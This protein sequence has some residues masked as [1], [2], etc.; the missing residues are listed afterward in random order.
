M[1][2]RTRRPSRRSRRPNQRRSNIVRTVSRLRGNKPFVTRRIASDPPFRNLNFQRTFTHRI[3]C[4]NMPGSTSGFILPV[5]SWDSVVFNVGSTDPTKANSNM[6]ITPLVIHSI[7]T[8]YYAKSHIDFAVN[9]VK[10]W[11][12][13]REDIPIRLEFAPDETDRQSTVMA[14]DVGTATRRARIGFATPQL[15]WLTL[16][17]VTKST[18]IV[19]VQWDTTH[20]RDTVPRTLTLGYLDMAITTRNT[21]SNLADKGYFHGIL[22][23]AKILSSDTK[24]SKCTSKAWINKTK[25]CSSDA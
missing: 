7:V 8:S 20:L 22:N 23:G 14:S 21:M 6:T 4:I 3:E 13:L 16:N 24:F 17:D 5:N 15:K 12:P 19:E 1:V 25:E 18:P 9:S 11:G 2:R 10:L